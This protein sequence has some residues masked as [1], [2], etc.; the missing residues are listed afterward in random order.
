M[1]DDLDTLLLNRPGAVSDRPLLG[2]TVLVVEDSRF[3]SEAMRLLCLRSGA[4]IRRADCLR[5]ARRH[6][7]V[8]RPQVVVIDL[9]LPD[10][11]GEALI[12]ELAAATPR[13]EAI[14]ACSG[15]D[16]AEARAG[17]AGA[18]GFLAKPVASLAQFQQA[19]LAHLPTG[20]AAIRALPDEEVSPD[21]FAFRDDMLHA[22]EVLAADGDGGTL[23]YLAQ[24]LGTV[25]RS[26]RDMPLESA[27]HRLAERRR[28]GAGAEDTLLRIASLVDARIAAAGPV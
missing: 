5:S 7:Q 13:V 12:A 25:A 26:A 6:L 18:D 11:K 20:S 28:A 1:T 19:I 10:G 22:A 21:R 4:R 27:A 2:Q 8:Y 17:A 24:F 14:L 15:D 3:A 9:G 23:D 16:G